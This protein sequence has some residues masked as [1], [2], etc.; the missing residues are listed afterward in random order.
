MGDGQQPRT[1]HRTCLVDDDFPAMTVRP[2]YRN[3]NL[4]FGIRCW[5]DA[6]PCSSDQWP[7]RTGD[8]GQFT[9]QSPRS[10]VLPPAYSRK[11]LIG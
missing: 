6:R 10:N 4:V 11:D 9:S 3:G 7:L 2:R 1:E 8:V 5:K